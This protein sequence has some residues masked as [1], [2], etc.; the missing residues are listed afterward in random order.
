MKKSAL[1]IFSVLIIL[2]VSSYAAQLNST[3]YRQNIIVS[4]G[5]DSPNST[6][7][8]TSLAVGII[9]GIIN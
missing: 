1:I 6:S 8:K 9:N 2:S 5:G 4:M 7:Y 3:S